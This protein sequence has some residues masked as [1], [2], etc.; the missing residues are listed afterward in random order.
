MTEIWKP[1][2]RAPGYEVSNQG[3]IRSFMKSKQGR[4]MSTYLSSNG[5][6]ALYLRI[7]KTKHIAY[8]HVEVATAFLG[9]R[10]EGM[11]IRHLDGDPTN[12]CVDNL[13]YG[14]QVDNMNDARRHGTLACGTKL[15]Q[16]KLNPRKVRIIR[17]LRKLGFTVPRLSSMFGVN[18]R[19]IYRVITRESW[20]NVD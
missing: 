9:E 5:R 3:R 1:I 6:Y 17:G 19:N 20:A 13:T 12:N 7:D 4:L 15:P 10:P 8:V 2:E 16:A 18:I 11:V 14:T